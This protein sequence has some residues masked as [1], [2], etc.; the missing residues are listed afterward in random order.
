MG[1]WLRSKYKKPSAA[2]QCNSG[3]NIWASIVLVRQLSGAHGQGHK[4]SPGLAGSQ[5]GSGYPMSVLSADGVVEEFGDRWRASDLTDKMPKPEL[6]ATRD[7]VELSAIGTYERYQGNGY[8]T[9]ALKM[10]IDLC[11]ENGVEIMLVPRALDPNLG[12]TPGCPATLTT[13]QIVAWYKRYGFIETRAAGE[14]TRE[15]IWKLAPR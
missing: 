1:V 10:L 7:K 15:M 5:N 2:T 9:R 8:A 12:V 13:E 3:R 6:S 14:G 11:D 4:L